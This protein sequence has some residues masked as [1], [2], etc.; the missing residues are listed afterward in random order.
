MVREPDWRFPFFPSSEEEERCT[1]C[2]YRNGASANG[3]KR[4]NAGT[5]AKKTN[6]SMQSLHSGGM[7]PTIPGKNGHPAPARS[8]PPDYH[9][10]MRIQTFHP[11]I[12]QDAPGRGRSLVSGAAVFLAS[13][14]IAFAASGAAADL[15][16]RSYAYLLS[17][18]DVVAL[19][20]VE[21]LS[22]GFLTEGRK[23][24]V[25]VDALIKGKVYAKEIKV[26]WNDKEFEETAYKKDGKVVLF[27]DMKKDTTYS[28]VSPGISCW[29]VEMVAIK[30]KPMRA[31]EYSYPMDL[32]TEVP[33]SSLRET[34]TM[35]KSMNFQMAKRKTWILTDQLLPPSHPVVLPK[36]RP[37]PKPKK[38][39]KPSRPAKPSK[40]GG[41]TAV[42]PAAKSGS[43]RGSAH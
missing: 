23:A 12:P 28:Q 19:G 18:A 13:A 7:A 41:K 5:A 16:P 15:Q 4:P 42:K 27:L 29:P 35:E 9:S 36:P 3:P 26:A 31:V 1:R 6:Q 8:K 34:E 30:G 20:T 38:A 22:G 40:S 2:A 33:P 39:I 24:T 25:A 10:V 32:M 14:L 11:A 43:A 37:Q 17:H 21:G